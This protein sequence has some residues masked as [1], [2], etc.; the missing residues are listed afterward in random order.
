MNEKIYLDYNATA[1]IR[2][3][4]IDIMNETMTHAHNASSVHYAG[5]AGRKYIEDA[6]EAISG[7]I[8][9]PTAQIIF[10][11]GATE[12]NNTVLR[13]FAETYPNEQILVSA[14][15]HPSVLEAIPNATIIPVTNGGT[16]DLGALE[17]L[18]QNKASLVSTMFVNNETGITQPIKEIS[19]LAHRHGALLHVD[20]VQ[21]VGRIEIDAPA[22]GIDFLTLSAHKLGGPQGVGAL[23]LGLCGIT[24][25][26]LHGGGQEKSTRAGTENVAGI[27]GFGKAIELASDNIGN[28]QETTRAFQTKLEEHLSQINGL[29]ICGQNIDRATNTTLIS[30]PGIS[31]ETLLMAF[32]LEGIAI[33]N[34]SACSSGKVEPSH[35][36]KAMG[37]SD[38]AASG[39]L[40]I[41]T[42]WNTSQSDIETFL[43]A[44][45]KIITRMKDKI[46]A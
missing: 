12:G 10:N 5:R 36:L 15:E 13:Y 31:S 28:F 45:D 17:K 3:E 41:S 35:V 30:L 42:G 11:S 8:N 1:P 33:S 40:R 32:D 23:G 20:A 38:E 9:L 37:E 21:A 7:L 29:K 18:L 26:L 4:V 44:F 46:V 34:G 24:P 27:A 6:R 22:L 14:I 16:V 39:A 43:T 19:A 2:P 25:T